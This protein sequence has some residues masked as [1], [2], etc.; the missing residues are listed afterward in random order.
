MIHFP[1]VLH[2]MQSWDFVSS[3]RFLLHTRRCWDFVHRFSSSQ[4]LLYAFSKLPEL[5]CEF[6]GDLSW[7]TGA[8]WSNRAGKVAYESRRDYIIAVKGK[9]RLRVTLSTQSESA[10]FRRISLI[11]SSGDLWCGLV[12]DGVRISSLPPNRRI[13]RQIAV[14]QGTSSTPTADHLASFPPAG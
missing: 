11:S 4:V 6:P 12:H 10:A 8:G 13:T 2:T 5:D 1:F 14:A 7:D 3:T 9:M